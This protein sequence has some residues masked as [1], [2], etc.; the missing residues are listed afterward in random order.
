MCRE[1]EG[2]GR[3]QSLHFL[4][5][6]S[7]ECGYRLAQVEIGQGDLQ[8]DDR[9]RGVILDG[10]REQQR[11]AVE[12]RF[13]L[14]DAQP[15]LVKVGLELVPERGIGAAQGGILQRVEHE[16]DLLHFDETAGRN[17]LGI[18]LSGQIQGEFE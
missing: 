13:R 14:V 9:R 12:G 8:V 16:V 2:A 4:H 15:G 6:G 7:R 1:V 18:A 11:Y 17:H 10:P 3:I 5:Q